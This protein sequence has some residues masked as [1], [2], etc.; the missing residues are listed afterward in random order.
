MCPP[1]GFTGLRSG[2]TSIEASKWPY[3]QARA[4]AAGVVKV[5]IR[6]RLTIHCNGPT[7]KERSAQDK[8]VDRQTTT[9]TCRQTQK[10]AYRAHTFSTK[11][12]Q[13][14]AS[15]AMTNMTRDGAWCEAG[16]C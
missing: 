3:I 12:R 6:S 1:S 5:K 10:M 4:G 2:T 14:Q 16:L 11:S 9:D 8:Q 15:V 13:L 7:V